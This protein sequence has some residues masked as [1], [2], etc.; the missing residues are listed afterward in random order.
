MRVS[1]DEDGLLAGWLFVVVESE[2]G[3]GFEVKAFGRADDAVLLGR[4]GSLAGARLRVP[5]GA[6]RV[7][8]PA[9]AKGQWVECWVSAL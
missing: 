1:V 8:V 6:F 5:A 7:P 4:I 3:G 2:G 9:V